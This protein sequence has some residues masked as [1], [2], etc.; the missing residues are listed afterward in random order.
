MTMNRFLS[1]QPFG[2]GFALALVRII[3]GAFLIY[4]GR[5]VFDTVVMNRYLD[6]EMFNKLGKTMI[7]AGKASELISGILLAL[8][9]LTRPAAILVI[10]TL[11]Y[12]SF[13]IGNGEIWMD[14]QYPFLFVLFGVVFLFVG[15][16]KLSLDNLIFKK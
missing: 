2:Q 16:S 7:Y 10:V 11:G 14:A 5:E 8:G 4:H 3:I 1:P 6:S 9:L 12:I 15:G 13:F